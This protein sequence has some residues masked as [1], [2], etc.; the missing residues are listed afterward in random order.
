MEIMQKF[1]VDADT[2][3][4][5]LW[6]RIRDELNKRLLSTTTYATRLSQVNAPHD[7]DSDDQFDNLTVSFI[8]GSYE[9]CLIFY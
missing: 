4:E 9:P 2:T 6:S 1:G 8:I 3:D 5:S 7:Q